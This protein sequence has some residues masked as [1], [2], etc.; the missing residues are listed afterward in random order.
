MDYVRNLHFEDK[1]DY[2]FLR[3]ISRN[4]F[5]R[6]SLEHDSVFDWP[7]LEFQKNRAETE[8]WV[9]DL[10]PTLSQQIAPLC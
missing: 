3:K 10:S 2:T 5:R 1:L 4:L 9:G 6:R 8:N 7:L